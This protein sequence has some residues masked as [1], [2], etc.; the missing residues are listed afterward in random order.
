MSRIFVTAALLAAVA[1]GSLLA[2]TVA[3]SADGLNPQPFPPKTLKP[4]SEVALSDGSVA[5]VA[6]DGMHL[7]SETAGKS[8]A[9]PP[10]PCKL[11]NGTVLIIG[12]DGL[13]KG[14]GSAT[15]VTSTGKKGD[16]VH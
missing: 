3:A 6:P 16:P 15:G 9:L 11:K 4:N 14:L 13:V 5:H 8:V 10:G 2:G 12:A 1:G 7:T